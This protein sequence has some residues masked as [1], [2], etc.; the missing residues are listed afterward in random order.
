MKSTSITRTLALVLVAVAMTGCQPKAGSSI[1]IVDLEVV[2][3]K[4]GKSK[5][6]QTKIEQR[7]QELNQSLQQAKSNIDGQLQSAAGKLGDSQ[8]ELA[9]QQ[10]V[11][12]EQ[13]G[14]KRLET[15][16]VEGESSLMQYRLQVVQ[17]FR[18]TIRPIS[19]TVAKRNGCNVVLTKTDTVIFA[20]A[21]EVDITDEIVSSMQTTVKK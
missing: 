9:R 12:L 17:Q 11:A 3:E 6:M 16:R 15:F 4:L 5:E 19:L 20:Y 1:A 10:Y 18:D 14:R 13:E 2:A 7:Q 8:D 21:S